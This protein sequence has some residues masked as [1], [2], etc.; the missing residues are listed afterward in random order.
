MALASLDGIIPNASSLTS[1]ASSIIDNALTGTPS[2][3]LS[4]RDAAY[5]GARSGM[6]G[7]EL[8]DRFG[9]DIYNQRG[10]AKQQQG[11][12]DL[13]ALLGTGSQIQN[14]GYQQWL[15][16]QNLNLNAAQLAQQGSSEAARLAEEQRQFDE[17][18]D[19]NKYKFNRASVLDSR[20]SSGGGGSGRTLGLV[21]GGVPSSPIFNS[22]LSQNHNSGWY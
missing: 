7:S 10:D 21:G 11:F 13:L 9:F 19:F 22:N 6:P 17:Q 12:Q 1:S 16:G 4:Q 2:P 20:N 5:F 18:F 15:G 3:S 8:A 14:Q